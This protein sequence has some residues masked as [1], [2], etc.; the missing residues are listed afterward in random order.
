MVSDDDQ[1][2]PADYIVERVKKREDTAAGCRSLAEDDRVRAA[3]HDSLHM[4]ACLERSADT[5]TARANL[6]TRLEGARTAS[7]DRLHDTSEL[8]E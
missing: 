5:W 2:K 3:S 1:P 4:R 6:L 7:P 8:G